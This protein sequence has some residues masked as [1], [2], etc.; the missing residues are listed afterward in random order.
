MCNVCEAMLLP[1]EVAMH[2]LKHSKGEPGTNVVV[3]D[4]VGELHGFRAFN[5]RGSKKPTLISLN[6]QAEWPTD[7]WMIA[8][9]ANRMVCP[10]SDDKKVP[11]ERCS[12]GIYSARDWNHLV[13]INYNRYSDESIRVVGKVGLAGKVI[14]ASQGFRAE[15]ARV[16]ELWVPHISWRLVKPLQERYGVPVHLQNTLVATDEEEDE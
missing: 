16:I 12:C 1:T 4:V 2:T 6:A 10:K 13:S 8:T 9:C 3:P 7:N 5:V 14:P 15:K 11:G